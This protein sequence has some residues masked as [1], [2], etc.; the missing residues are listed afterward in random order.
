[1]K[2]LKKKKHHFTLLELLI[3]ILVLSLGA[4]LTGVQMHRVFQEQR[5]LSEVQQVA[6]QL[7]LAQDLMLVMD[8]DVF[9]HL[10]RDKEGKNLHYALEVE[11]PLS[12]YWAKVVE[13]VHPPLTSIRNFE[14]MGVTEYVREEGKEEDEL[15]LRFSFG[16]MCKGVLVLTPL[17]KDASS[18]EHQEKDQA[19]VLAGYPRPISSHSVRN[20]DKEMAVLEEAEKRKGESEELY[21]QELKEEKP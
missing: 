13:A 17:E 18:Q 12:G 3:V 20:L 14:F 10:R 1:M 15:H 8:T 21:P 4:A 6:N 11:K 9:L 2:V 19:I 7:Q 16:K 5:F